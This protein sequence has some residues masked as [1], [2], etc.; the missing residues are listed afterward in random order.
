VKDKT[1]LL[2][3]ILLCA[4]IAGETASGRSTILVITHV[5]VIDATER[6]RG[7]TWPC[8]SRGIEVQE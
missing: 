5:T 2:L 3:L 4:L 8:L 6:L 1:G 7:P